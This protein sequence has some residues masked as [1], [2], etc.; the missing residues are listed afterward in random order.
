MKRTYDPRKVKRH[1]SYTVQDLAALYE[2]GPNTVRQ[3]IKK[4]GLPVIEGS[5]PTLMHW[6]EIRRWIIDWQSARKW[7]CAANEMSCLRCQAPRKVKAGTFRVTESNKELLMMHGDCET[8]GRAMNRATSRA[9]LNVSKA[10][11]TQSAVPHNAP[12]EAHTS[13]P[14][15]PLNP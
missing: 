8:C 14:Q 11:F 9:K 13:N 7:T 1:R 3:W 4:Q 15:S 6:A 10:N 12:P 5:Y 2:V